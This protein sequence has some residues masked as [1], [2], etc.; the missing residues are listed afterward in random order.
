MTLPLLAIA[1]A[2]PWLGQRAPEGWVPATALVSV[3]LVGF[4]FGRSRRV[5]I[6]IDEACALRLERVGEAPDD[7]AYRAVLLRGKEREVVTDDASLATVA[8]DVGRLVDATRVTLEESC[9]IPVE[10]FRSTPVTVSPELE[11][12]VVVGRPSP[13]HLRAARGVVGSAAFAALV[14]GWSV[15]RAQSPVSTLSVM[16][17]AAFV[18]GLSAFGAWLWSLRIRVEV[19]QRGVLVERCALGYRRRSLEIPRSELRGAWVVESAFQPTHVL[20]ATSRG[21]RVVAILGEAAR[22]LAAAVGRIPAA[23]SGRRDA[24][25]PP[26]EVY[27]DA[28]CQSGVRDGSPEPR[29]EGRRPAR[30]EGVR[31]RQS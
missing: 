18:L 29:R 13:S 24:W 25:V 15:V 11:P 28:A 9:G 31:A 17:P 23:P 14:F 7:P 6:P 16:L 21:P 10:F 22:R 27:D 4:V 8:R 2:L 26:P 3:V 19:S 30:S 12:V 20:F 1:A 5:R